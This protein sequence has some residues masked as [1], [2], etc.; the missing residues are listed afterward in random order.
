MM[1]WILNNSQHTKLTLEKKIILPL[2]PGLK[3]TTF[4]SRIWHFTNK[5]FWNDERNQKRQICKNHSC[6]KK[7]EKKLYLDTIQNTIW[8]FSKVDMTWYQTVSGCKQAQTIHCSN[9]R[10][11]V[12]QCKNHTEHCF[13][14]VRYANVGRDGFGLYLP[15]KQHPQIQWKCSRWILLG[16]CRQKA[17]D[18]T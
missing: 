8:I 18:I 11:S 12:K 15:T 14:E 16:T 10:G 9:M 17:K 7:T 6:R 3:L 13:Q 5:L 1:E 2:L 4:R